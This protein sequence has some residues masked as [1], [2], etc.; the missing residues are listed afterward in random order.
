[1]MEQKLD[2]REVVNLE[3]KGYIELN[4]QKNLV[5]GPVESVTI[6]ENDLVHIK[7]A[8]AG[9]KPLIPPGIPDPNADWKKA[10]DDE[11]VFPNLAVSFVVESTPDKGDRVRFGQNIIYIEPVETKVQIKEVIGD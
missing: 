6:D 4:D 3:P 9:T 5:H 7:M 8:W 11:V 10:K 1:M 2:W